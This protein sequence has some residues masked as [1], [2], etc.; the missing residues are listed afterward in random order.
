MLASVCWNM[1]GRYVA[2]CLEVKVSEDLK[3]T[4]IVHL[5][6]DKGDEGDRKNYTRLSLLSVVCRVF[7]GILKDFVRK[8]IDG[9]IGDD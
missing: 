7:G 8:L 3:N 5:Y 2:W 9:R 1:Y 4:V 6:K